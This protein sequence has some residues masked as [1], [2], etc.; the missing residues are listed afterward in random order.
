M[1]KIC[2]C[3]SPVAMKAKEIYEAGSECT[4][5]VVGA[6]IAGLS[7]AI[8]LAR[9]GWGVT[10]IERATDPGEVGA[11]LAISRNAVAAFRGLGFDQ[12]T[13]TALGY[14]TWA[15]G[16]RSRA[17]RE[18]LRVPNRRGVRESVSLIG[19]H[20][21][22]LH[23]ALLDRAERLGVEVITG[24]P[25]TDV[26]PGD[27]R[28]SPAV[29]ADHQ[30]DLVIGADGMHSA[31]RTA[32]FPDIKAVYSGYSSWRAIIPRDGESTLQQYW[33]PHAEFGIL[34]VSDSQTYWYGYVGM[35]ECTI[36]ANEL[37]TARTRFAG[38]DLPVQQILER[39]S[40]ESVIRHDVFHLP[41]GVPHYVRGRVVMIGDA[42]HG[43]LPTLGQ[44]AV[45]ALEDGVCAGAVIGDAVPSGTDLATALHDFDVARRRRGRQLARG[46]QTMARIG[47]HLGPGWP[48]R[49]RNQLLRLVPPTA[50]VRASR[51]ILDWT[52]PKSPASSPSSERRPSAQ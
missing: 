19:V 37:D 50:M 17:G 36:L 24:I 34:P 26:D 18:I 48:Q 45:S 40:P 46:A 42:A 47:A 31:L 49:I 41:A 25:V 44:G 22:R 1:P 43:S 39:T 14:F 35:P 11:G 27:P 6:G 32:L 29:V 12:K 9:A 16:I 23:N 8:I 28:G 10:V 15:E 52:P 5:V 30:A 13:L 21:Q 20:R 2:T 51:T 33:G 7:A 38:W 3:V 4:A